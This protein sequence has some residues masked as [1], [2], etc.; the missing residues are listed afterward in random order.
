MSQPGIMAV[1]LERQ[2]EVRRHYGGVDDTV[3]CL[4][5]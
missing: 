3:L 2:G 1:G 5:K 4:V